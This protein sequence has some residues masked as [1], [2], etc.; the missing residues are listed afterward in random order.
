[1]GAQKRAIVG[2]TAAIAARV[3]VSARSAC[4][5]AGRPLARETGIGF[6]YRPADGRRAGRGATPIFAVEGGPGYGSSRTAP[7]YTALFGRLLKAHD[8]V[9][10]DM[11]GTGRSEPIRCPDL[12]QGARPGLADDG[13]GAHRLGP[14]VGAADLGGAEIRPVDVG[15]VDRDPARRIGACDEVLVG[16]GA[17]EVGAA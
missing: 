1:M 5:G 15:S 10:V 9:L 6:A 14:Q 17:V 4:L 13:R 7:A 16:A 2:A 12:N 11:R 3:A 8:L